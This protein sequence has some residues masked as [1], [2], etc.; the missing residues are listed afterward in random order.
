MSAAFDSDEFAGEPRSEMK[1]CL[2]CGKQK[3][4]RQV[5]GEQRC[6]ACNAAINAGEPLRLEPW[7]RDDE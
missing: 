3:Q 5:D 4:I 7:M 2:R 1:V 6:A